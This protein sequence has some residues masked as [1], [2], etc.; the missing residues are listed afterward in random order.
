[1]YIEDIDISDVEVTCVG[2][3]DPNEYVRKKIIEGLKKQ[4]NSLHLY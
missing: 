3:I 2:D 1:M 4:E